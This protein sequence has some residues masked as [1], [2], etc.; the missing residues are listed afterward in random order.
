VAAI[1]CG[2]NTLRL[3]VADL[4]G[5]VADPTALPHDV[6]RRTR[7]VRLG[8]GVHRT[9]RLAPEAIERTRSILAEYAHEIHDLGAERVRC[10]ATAAAR[11]SANADEFCDMVRATLGIEPEILT[12]DEEARLSFTGGLLGLPDDARAPYLT[13]D[14]GA[15]STEFAVG[16]RT[17]RAAVSTDLGCLRIAERYLCG[18]PPTPAQVAEAEAVIVTAVDQALSALGGWSAGTLIGLAGSV[19]QVEAAAL[20]VTRPGQGPLHHA[21][22]SYATV[23]T[24]AAGLLSMTSWQ[25]RS[26]PH[27]DPRRADLLGVAALTLRTVMRRTGTDSVV[28]SEHDI[29][30]GIAWSLVPGA[31]T[32]GRHRSP[33]LT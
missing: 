8:Q 7:N 28:A 19:G 31:V 22:I 3:L 11:N 30:D 4:P 2:T 5:S 26:I 23:T 14:I 1:D 27:L 25:R 29:L 9:G 15:G 20:W 18:D 24:L 32:G 16:E 10:C 12:G 13:V 33:A 6:V 17:V 21:R